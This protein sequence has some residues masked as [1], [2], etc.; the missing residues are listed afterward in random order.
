MTAAGSPRRQFALEVLKT[1]RAAGHTAYWAGGCVRDMLL[2]IEPKDY[3]V[4]TSAT[5]D[6]VRRLFGPRRT[7]EIGAAFGVVVVIG[8]RRAGQVEVTT[9]RRDA[10][11]SDGRHPDSVSFSDPREDAQRRDFTINGLFYDPLADEVVDFVGGR[12]D[13]QHGILRAIGDPAERFREDKL[14]LLR[15]VRFAARF[16]LQVDPATLAAVR[17]MAR[18]IVVVSAERIA[19]EMRM[20]LVH[21]SR[22]QACRLLLDCQLLA[23]VLPEVLPLCGTAS[24]HTHM[25]EDLWDHTLRVLD[26]LHR[27]DFPL[28]L[29]ALLHE[30]GR[31]ADGAFRSHSAAAEIAERI[32][33]AVCDRWRLSNDERKRACWLVRHQR[34]LD[35]ARRMPWS[36]LQPL[37][38]SEGIEDLL[39]LHEA[40][41]RSLARET[42]DVEHCRHKLQLPPE[43][44]NPPPLITGDDLKRH[45]IPPG[46][47]YK[48]LLQAARDAQLDGLIHTPSE[49]LALAERVMTE[50]KA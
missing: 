45:G 31:P 16:K 49:A 14:R 4:A 37:L 22:A 48:S 32:T 10:Q 6:E 29:A 39:A 41:A 42:L 5:P 33:N 25:A 12:D 27:P 18:Q 3:D 43:E 28:A 36:Q 13:L 50:P 9:F 11:Y 23:A 26:L 1:L 21:A 30:T 20:M 15:A 8:P 40:E 2:G 17:R 38:V 35:E 44:L 47:I 34:A 19:Q 7:L 24:E 46:K